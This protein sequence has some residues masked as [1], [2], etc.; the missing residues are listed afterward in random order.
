MCVLGKGGAKGPEKNTGLY[1]LSLEYN[2]E[3]NAGKEI[4]IQST[5]QNMGSK[6]QSS[7]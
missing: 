3:L 1:V 5:T 4:Q 7:I 2:F 6:H